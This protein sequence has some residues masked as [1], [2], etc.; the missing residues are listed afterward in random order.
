MIVTVTLNAA[1][2]RRYV[3]ENFTEGE[4]TRVKEC[5][6]TAG[7]KG[8]NVARLLTILDAKVTAT[9][10]LGGYAGMYIEHEIKSQGVETDFHHVEAESRCCINLW[11]ENKKLQSEFL[12]PGFE[13]N[14]TSQ[15][16]FLHKFKQVIK[17]ASVITLS[18]SAPKG[19]GTDFYPRLIKLAK[20]QKKKVILDTSGDFLTE[21][22]KAKPTLIKPNIDEIR[23]LI[24]KP[25]DSLSEIVHAARSIHQEG[26]D[27]VVVSL[28][29]SGSVLAC[30][31]GVY[32][33]IVPEIAALNSVGCGDAMIAGFAYSLE[34]EKTPCEALLYASAVSAAS[35]MRLETGYF[36]QQDREKLMDKIKIETIA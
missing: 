36:K 16:A 18:G 30:K 13:V 26:I 20:E 23:M 21:G 5:R 11:D 28:G 10:Y 14:Q 32:R 19:I 27:M 22:I 17:D 25:C 9:G 34:K 6:A 12:E 4:V 15:E 1:I 33:A 35:A 7:G 8:L 29:K 24:G 2:D 3:V 31:E